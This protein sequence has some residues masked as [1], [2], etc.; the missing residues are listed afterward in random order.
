MALAEEPERI[1]VID[2]DTVERAGVRYRLTGLDAAEINHA[3]CL[4]ECQLGIVT[5]A[6]LIELIAKRGANLDTGPQR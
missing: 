5:A 4:Q 6:W 2:G 3:K 1:M